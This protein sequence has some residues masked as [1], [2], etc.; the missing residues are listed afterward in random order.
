[1]TENR[2]IGFVNRFVRD[3]G[4]GGLEIACF[5]DVAT[6]LVRSLDSDFVT[7]PAIARMIESEP[8]TGAT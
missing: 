4:Q 8:T 7:M 5:P 3:M 2:G 1:M 6:K